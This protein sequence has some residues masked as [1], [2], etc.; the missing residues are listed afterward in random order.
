VDRIERRHFS[1]R[2]V[3]RH[4]RHT[5]SFA[6]APPPFPAF[7]SQDYDSTTFRVGG[8]LGYDWQFNPNWLVGLEGDFAWGDAKKHVDALQGTAPVGTGSS[9]EVR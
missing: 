6:G 9:S 5:L 8:Y 7:A 3:R 4:H 1:R 2:A